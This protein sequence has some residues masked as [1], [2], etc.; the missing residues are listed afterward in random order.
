MKH[1]MSISVIVLWCAVSVLLTTSA[2]A[3][4]VYTG[5]SG[6]VWKFN[7]PALDGGGSFV[8]SYN[9]SKDL[10]A[11]ETGVYMTT[12]GTV[13]KFNHSGTLIAASFTST[14]STVA[15]GKDGYVY[16]SNGAEIGRFNSDLTGWTSLVTAG[17]MTDIAADDTGIYGTSGGTVYRFNLAG[18]WTGANSTF[19]GGFDTVATIVVPEPLTMAVLFLGGITSA[20]V[21]SRKK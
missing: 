2:D 11:D 13:W 21:R 9:G 18:G 10:A 6:E 17:E 14:F 15:V 4:V 19:N 7:Q 1:A 12:A 5:N 3:S 16:V 20:V 8:N